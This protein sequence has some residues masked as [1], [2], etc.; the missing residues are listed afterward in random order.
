M[1]NAAFRNDFTYGEDRKATQTI[2]QVLTN[3]DLGSLPLDQLFAPVGPNGDANPGVTIEITPE[4]A[5]GEKRYYYVT[6]F[7]IRHTDSS[8]QHDLTCLFLQDHT[9][10]VR[11]EH[12]Q[13]LRDWCTKRAYLFRAETAQAIHSPDLLSEMAAQ[14]ADCL[15][16]F[17]EVGI[18]ISSKGQ[19]SIVGNV[20]TGIPYLSF[21]LTV[22]GE[23]YGHLELFSPK[24]PGNLAIQREFVD[25]L[26][27]IAARRL[28]SRT[29]QLKLLQTSQLHALGEMAAGVAHELNQPL[30]G[31]R[32]FAESI[33]FGMQHG[34]ET[35]PKEVQS[36]LEDIVGQVDRMTK[37]INH[38]RDFSR[39]SSEE[40]AQ[41]FSIEEVIG[42]VFK[43]VETQLRGH[44]IAIEKNISS[45]LP[46][47]QGWPQQLEQ[48]L[49]NLI[50]NARQ[51]MDERKDRLYQGIEVD[52][53]WAPVLAI[54]IDESNNDLLIEVADT[55]GGIP[56][57]IIKSIFDPFFTSKEVGQGTGLGLSISYSIVQKHGGNIYVENRP[58]AGATFCVRLPLAE[59]KH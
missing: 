40:D 13:Q 58:G 6:A 34:W 49:L 42:N 19:Q 10:Q 8:L 16:H 50:T 53:E 21:S 29:Q 17:N 1:T 33:L 36:T 22:E 7:S 30:T 57:T 55:G 35:K 27:D 31:I 2:D 51:A 45:P 18:R 59:K 23:G 24:P 14:L 5:G 28:E 32:T 20:A 4:V 46:T 38:M 25:T 52:P 37:I 26:A 9:L 47:C 43:L 12:E 39:D 56:E 54:D 44:G 41:P 48:V 3:F 15:S 11:L